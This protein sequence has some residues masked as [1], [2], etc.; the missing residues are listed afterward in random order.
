MDARIKIEFF[1]EICPMNIVWNITL[2]CGLSDWIFELSAK[3]FHRFCE[4]CGVRIFAR[5]VVE[6][7]VW[8]TG[9]ILESALCLLSIRETMTRISSR[10]IN[11]D[12]QFCMHF[13][14]SCGW[15]MRH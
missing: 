10:A 7:V 3:D 5:N 8:D 9:A 4:M 6:R 13:V 11:C 15:V 1:S 12:V 14:E 2:L